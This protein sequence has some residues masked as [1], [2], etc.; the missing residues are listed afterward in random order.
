VKSR[1]GRRCLA[2]YGSASSRLHGR[3]VGGFT[4]VELLVSLLLAGLL[5]TAVVGAY[6]EALRTY[7]YQEQLARMQENG[8]FTLRLLERELSMAGFYA[9]IF[10]SDTIPAES[11]GTDCASGNWALDPNEALDIV[12]DYSGTASPRA[13]SGQQ[14]TCV[15]NRYLQQGSDLVAVKRTFSQASVRR[16]EA[17]ASVTPST[18]ELWYLRLTSGVNPQWERREPVSLLPP[19]VL[20][21]E[22]S[23]WEVS[24]KL[25]FVRSYS[26]LPADSIPSLCMEVLAGNAMTARCLAEGI[27]DL[28][29]EFGVDSDGDGVANRYV[30]N[31]TEQ[32][33]ANA[34]TAKVF[35]LVRSV[36]AIAGQSD[37][38][39]YHLGDK[40]V[41]AK[42]DRYL[43]QVYSTTVAL[44]NWS[45]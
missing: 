8:R 35:V 19:R 37:Q 12:H 32:E 18:V 6:L 44:K 2:I 13:V 21:A 26:S 7:T 23:L 42:N 3:Q 41:P 9:G 11:V 16:G 28:Q 24:V 31:A 15:D 5:S 14:F 38:S 4:L 10:P 39:V 1:Y 36:E 22:E 43:R 20:A 40:L 17:A 45:S 33:L 27:E 25:F 30:A 34:I 29:I